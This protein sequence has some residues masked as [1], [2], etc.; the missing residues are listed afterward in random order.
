MPVP[1]NG[2]VIL[3]LASATI[4]DSAADNRRTLEAVASTGPATD[5]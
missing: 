5:A 3:A 1:V 4:L 2:V